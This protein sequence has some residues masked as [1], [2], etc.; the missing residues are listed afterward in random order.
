MSM[1]FNCSI[2]WRTSRVPSTSWRIEVWMVVRL[3]A[4]KSASLPGSVML[5]ASAWRSSDSS[6]DS[7]T[8]CWK[9]PLTLRCRA[10]MA[11]RSDSRRTSA[12]ART[13]ARMYGFVAST[14][15]RC[16][17]DCPCTMR[18]R[19]PSGSLNILWMWVRVPMAYSSSWAG[20]SVPGSSWVKTPTRLLSAMASSISCTE[21]SRATARGMKEFGKRTVSRRGNTGSSDGT[22]TRPGS[23]SSSSGSSLIV[24]FL[25]VPPTAPDFDHRR[26]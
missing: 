17:R 19:V 5:P 6:G 20:S 11:R 15:S 21:L 3:D 2:R 23:L 26:V 10:S 9:L 22:S 4:M 14:S 8:T 13:R 7:E 24:W 1:R 25:P 16:R 18:R 12:A